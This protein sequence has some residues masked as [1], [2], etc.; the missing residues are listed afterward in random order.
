M[1]QKLT[2]RN[3]AIC[4]MIAA[5]Y[6]TLCIATAPISFGMVQVRTAEA[7][8]LLPVFSPLGIW[9]VTLGCALSNLIGFMTG[10]NILGFTDVFL[11]TAAT[12]IAAVLS[13][14]LRG[15]RLAGLPVLS[16][17]PPVLVNAVVIGGELCILLTGGLSPKPFLINAAYVGLG[18]MISCF[19]LGLPLVYILQK[20][21]LSR[22]LNA[23]R[24]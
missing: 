6:T 15:I 2:P 10:A 22:L 4:A 24:S 1:K 16:A 21:G 23:N 7:F 9:G 14:R 18:Q 11:G 3:M 5:L 13:Y 20:T 17:V 19:V 12:L 8:T